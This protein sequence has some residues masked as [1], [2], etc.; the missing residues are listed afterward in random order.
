MAL[1]VYLDR[2]ENVTGRSDR[3]AKVS[4]RGLAQW[5]RIVQAHE[6]RALCIEFYEKLEWPVASNIEHSEV[7]DVQIFNV[8]KLTKNK[9]LGS[10]R[11]V[12]QQVVTDGQIKVTETLLDS[13]NTALNN[14]IFLRVEYQAVDGTVGSWKMEQFGM[15]QYAGDCGPGGGG[16]SSALLSGG[17]GSGMGGEMGRVHGQMMNEIQHPGMITPLGGGQR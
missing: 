3:V 8:N 11:M 6:I 13:N 17:G 14:R 5:T 1:N 10:F 2:V 12:L 15:D 9:L 7:L 16:E 4:F